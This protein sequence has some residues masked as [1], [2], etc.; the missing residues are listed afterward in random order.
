MVKRQR[1]LF[2]PPP[3]H[4][5][6][7]YA[8]NVLQLVGA[9]HDI[10][11]I[12]YEGALAPQF[13]GVDVVIDEGGSHGTREMMDVAGTVKLWQILGTGFDHFDLAYCKR[14]KIPVAN[15]PGQFS[16]V[17]LAEMALM[18]LLMLSRR[19]QFTQANLQRGIQGEPMGHELHGR[20]LG[21]IGFGAS[22]R[23][24]ARRVQLLGMRVMAI[25][26]RNVSVEE[27]KEF[28]LDFVG[29]PKDLDRVVSESDYLSLHLHLNAETR[30]I[31]DARRIGLMK[32]GASVINVAR[33]ALIDEEALYHALKNGRLGGAGLDVFTHEPM[34][35]N[36]PILKL[37]QVIA[38]PHIA[39]AT[40]GTSRRRATCAAENVD[41]IA[42]GLEPLY[43]IDQ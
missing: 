15:C 40:D 11:V 10:S 14:K 13:E 2:L 18:F 36:L 23:E 27:Q 16:A 17:G 33:G 43:R 31:M 8:E 9:K 3:P 4:R 29:G 26:I 19:W 42:A 21:L 24:F 34:D 37:P 5:D 38:T 41:R 6:R 30:H 12:N 35:P 7:Q 1:V 25:D 22:A 28:G 20:S 32:P 39:G